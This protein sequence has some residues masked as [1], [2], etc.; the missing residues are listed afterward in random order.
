MPPA[1]PKAPPPQTLS[2]TTWYWTCGCVTWTASGVK[3]YSHPCGH[4]DAFV[5]A[6]SAADIDLI[7]VT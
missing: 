6:A 7:A 3:P 5:A 1:K 4:A 2:A